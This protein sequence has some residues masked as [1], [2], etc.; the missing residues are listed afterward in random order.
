MSRY[1]LVIL[2]LAVGFDLA[3]TASCVNSAWKY[4]RNA[5]YYFGSGKMN[6]TEAKSGC[7]AMGVNAYLASVN[8]ALEQSFL[9][10]TYPAK[11]YWLGLEA[12]NGTWKWID[13][14]TYNYTNWNPNSS[15]S[16]TKCP[17]ANFE[18]ASGTWTTILCTRSNLADQGM[19]CK[20]Y[21]A[22]A[23]T[24]ADK[25]EAPCAFLTDFCNDPIYVNL[26][27]DQCPRTCGWCPTVPPSTCVD[28]DEASCLANR[29]NDRLYYD[30]MT[31]ACPYT[32]NRC[33]G[34]TPSCKDLTRAD[35]TSTCALTAYLCSDSL[36]WDLMTQQCPKT[37]NR[38]PP[39][40]NPVSCVDKVG[41]SGVSDCPRMSYLCNDAVYYD[42]MTEQCPKTCGRC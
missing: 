16:Q 40:A 1:L 14:T 21:P 12:I 4:F 11:K 22:S 42:L 20:Y 33:P 8:S 2:F 19:L 9:N 18:D 28:K 17:I 38:C 35:G 36:Y 3:L 32:C 7:A 23:S 10:T 34:Q 29:C 26:M 31:Q 27:T 25:P 41:Q 24:C 6:Y 13:G 15:P 5:C 30:L 39:R 37:C